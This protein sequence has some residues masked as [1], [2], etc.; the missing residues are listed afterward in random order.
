M[1]KRLIS[2]R[3]VELA[4][5]YPILAVVGPR[6]SGKSTVCQMA[7]RD[8]FYLNLEDPQTYLRVQADPVGEVLK[9]GPKIL[10]DEA[11]KWPALLSYLQVWTDT[12]R[13]LKIVITGSNHLQMME[14]ISQSLAGRVVVTQLLPLSQKELLQT[15][16]P[17]ILQHSLEERIFS[18]GYPRLYQEKLDP[19]LWLSQY[20]AAYIERDVRALLGIR[21]LDSFQ[22]FLALCAGRAGQL[23]NEASLASECGITHPTAKAWLS[24]LKASFICFTLKPHHRNF[25]KRLVKQPKLYFYD[26]GILCYLL[27]LQS[28]DQIK[29]HPA[30]GS[31]F[32][33]WVVAEHFKAAFNS[34][35]APQY[36]FWRD[37]QGHEVDL[38]EDTGLSLAPTEIKA[39]QT[40]LPDHTLGLDYFLKQQKKFLEQNIPQPQG[41]LIYAGDKSETF[42]QYKVISWKDV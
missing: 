24:V 10:I 29:L 31:L 36:Y 17:L 9:H 41:S 34:V 14:K 35:R 21:N 25:S 20:V 15:Q 8:Y 22:K 12:D 7:F 26:T 38:I 23:L 27:G 13:H 16:D 32:E 11:Q 28:P 33:N 37:H 5:Q 40:F 3:L 1:Y 42:K 30:R 39:S 4:Q 2:T 18:G 6:Q 19:Q